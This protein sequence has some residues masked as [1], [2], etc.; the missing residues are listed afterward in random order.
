MVLR[1]LFRLCFARPKCLYGQRQCVM[2]AHTYF[3]CWIHLIWCTSNRNAFFDERQSKA[4]SRYLTNYAKSKG[5]S[6]RIN[7]VNP[8]HVHV[9]IEV[10]P[11]MSVDRV[12]KLLK[13]SSSYWINKTGMTNV[14]FS[15]Q[16]GYAALS[17]SPQAVKT[18]TRYIAMQRWHHSRI[19]FETELNRMAPGWINSSRETVETVSGDSG[20]LLSPG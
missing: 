16:H 5:I 2:S 15:W 4:L 17:V 19:S 6:I 13:G 11:S 20:D 9:L 7:F 12:V 1:K 10:R 18:V 8:E 14:P 3:S